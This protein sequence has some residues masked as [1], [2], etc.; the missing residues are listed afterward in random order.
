LSI[1]PGEWLGGL[2]V[3]CDKGIDVILQLLDGMKE[4]PLR[5]WLCRI[6]NQISI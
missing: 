2:V 3:G 1:S 5:D 4:A 6:E